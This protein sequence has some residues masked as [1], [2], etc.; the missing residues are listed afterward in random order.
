MGIIYGY[1][2]ASTV[3]MMLAVAPA[4]TVDTL[5]SVSVGNKDKCCFS[6][7]KMSEFG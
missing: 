2:S 7:L 1:G 3:P 6:N 5:G 4:A